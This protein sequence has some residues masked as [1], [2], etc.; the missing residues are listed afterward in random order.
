VEQ[1]RE[2]V[3]RLEEDRSLAAELGGLAEALRSGVL[4]FA[5]P[6]VAV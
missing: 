6:E 2:L 5:T 3:P 4:V 1:V